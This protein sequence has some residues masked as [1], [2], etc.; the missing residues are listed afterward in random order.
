[1]QLHALGIVSYFKAGELSKAHAQLQSFELIYPGR[2]LFFADHTSFLETFRLL[3][4]DLPAAA[5]GHHSLVNARSE[6]KSE[7]RR[8]HYWDN[9]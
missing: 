6:T 3:L 9:H 7:L 1:M 8:Q 2:D 5:A 4:G